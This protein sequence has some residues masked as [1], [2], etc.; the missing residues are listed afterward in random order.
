MA[1]ER[2]ATEAAPWYLVP[3]DRKWYR[4]WAISTLLHEHLEGLDPQYPE[5]DFDVEAAR[6]NL[7][8]ME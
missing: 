8:A 5:A 3:A 6:E 1:L 7:L 2:C 4:N